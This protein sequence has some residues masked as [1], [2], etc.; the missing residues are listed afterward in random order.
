MNIL[1]ITQLYPQPDD[2]GDNKPTKTV[3]YFANEWRKS[4]H[5][6]YVIHCSS[7]FPFLFYYA[8]KFVKRLLGGV[9]SNI[10]PSKS[11][12]KPLFRE[13]NGIKVMR[14]PMY[15]LFP[16][17]GYTNH[18][19]H[20]QTA[21][22]EK[23]LYNQNFIPDL[24]AGHF[25]N[26]STAIVSVLSARYS[27]R[28]SIVFHNDCNIKNVRKYRLKTWLKNIDA[29]GTRSSYEAE[30]VKNVLNLKLLPF[31]CYS[32]VP[33][34]L[35]K[36]INRNHKDMDFSKGSNHLFVGSLIKRKKLDTVMKAFVS[37]KRNLDKL[38][39]IGGGPEEANMRKMAK[40]LDDNNSITFI[41]KIPRNDV[42]KEMIKAH[43]F[44]LVSHNEA[45]GMVYIEAMLNGCIV[46]ASKNGG[47]DGII[48]DGINGYLCTAGDVSMLQGIYN[49]I[50]SLSINDKIK[51]SKAAI[52]TA[53]HFSESEVAKKYLENIM[54][55]P[56]LFN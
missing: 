55:C 56:K 22:I 48:I 35:I 9:L 51:I 19:I 50:Y 39:I 20:K 41:G 37:T 3:E 16:G 8:P 25:A 36:T 15:K 38:I 7:K 23:F 44:T 4:G 1:L 27:S 17:M 31:I 53:S 13:E 54:N 32:G 5:N 33:N 43:I 21:L 24:V 29:I 30:Q 45:Y 49:K 11:S 46:I 34:D 14:Y 47:F 2:I 42:F 26:P 10:I 6:I 40:T 18:Q 28:S 52:E 12:R